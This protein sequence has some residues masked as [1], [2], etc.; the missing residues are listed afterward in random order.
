MVLIRSTE[1]GYQLITALWT[2]IVNEIVIAPAK[3][4]FQF[5][6]FSRGGHNY[7]TEGNRCVAWLKYF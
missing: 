7:V 4:H 1:Q 3:K 2:Y 5:V 6:F